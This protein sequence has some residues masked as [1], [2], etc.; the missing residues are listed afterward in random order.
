L[1]SIY[2]FL[3]KMKATNWIRLFIKKFKKLLTWKTQT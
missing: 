3:Q 2:G 1:V